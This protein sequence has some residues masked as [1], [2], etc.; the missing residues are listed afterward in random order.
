MKRQKEKA[1]HTAGTITQLMRLAWL[2]TIAIANG[3]SGISRNDICAAWRI[4]SPSASADIKEYMRM[5]GNDGRLRYDASASR[6]VWH[7]TAKTV[8]MDKSEIEPLCRRI[9]GDTTPR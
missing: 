2:E 3:S 4:S 7:G 9:L 5:T 1:P 8:L 6:Y